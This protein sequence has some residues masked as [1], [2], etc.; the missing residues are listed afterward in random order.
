V[1]APHHARRRYGGAPFGPISAWRD[2]TG[3][4]ALAADGRHVHVALPA[5]HREPDGDRMLRDGV[6]VTVDGRLVA[7]LVQ[8][9]HGVSRDSRVVHVRD[10]GAGVVPDGTYLRR[11]RLSEVWLQTDEQVLVRPAGAWV[12]SFRSLHVA[13]G[14]TDELALAYTVLREAVSFAV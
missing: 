7:T 1:E 2:H 3:A 8:E 12:L 13:P 5:T 4:H 6:A 9:R 11:R 10:P 14:V